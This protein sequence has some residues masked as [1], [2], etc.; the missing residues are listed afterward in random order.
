MG[1]W[2]GTTLA[3]SFASECC[4]SFRGLLVCPPLLQS[5]AWPGLLYV[6][7]RP[8]RLHTHPPL[9]PSGFAKCVLRSK[10]IKEPP[11]L[12]T[13]VLLLLFLN[14]LGGATMPQVA[15]RNSRSP[16]AQVAWGKRTWG[17]K[18][19]GNCMFSSA[20]KSLRSWKTWDFHWDWHPWFCVG[21]CDSTMNASGC[22]MCCCIG[23]YT[24][25]SFKRVWPGNRDGDCLFILLGLQKLGPG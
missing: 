23:A 1:A 16:S 21:R 2:G 15:C 7:V 24:A 4:L 17:R 3:S 6:A 25:N 11:H 22:T 18:A 13:Q 19:A 5:T 14:P 9:D 12:D 8:V 10:C 20:R